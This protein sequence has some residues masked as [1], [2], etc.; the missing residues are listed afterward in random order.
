MNPG[1]ATG[2]LPMGGPM[3]A[4]GYILKYKHHLTIIIVPRKRRKEP[5]STKF[6]KMIEIV[7]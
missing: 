5:Q 7:K 2:G 1:A 3:G 6:S 4:P